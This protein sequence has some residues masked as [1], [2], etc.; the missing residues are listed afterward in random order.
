MDS[1]ADLLQKKADN[2]DLKKGD[3]LQIIQIELDRLFGIGF[4]KA[5]II[6]DRKSALIITVKNPGDMTTIRYGQI[7]I[8][9]AI[10]NQTASTVKQIIVR[11]SQRQE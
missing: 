6:D 2:L 8:L 4:A 5:S 1:I 9:S 7:Q 10:S 11:L 3:D